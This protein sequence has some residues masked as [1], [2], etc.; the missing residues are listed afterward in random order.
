MEANLRRQ[1]GELFDGL[2]VRAWVSMIFSC[3]CSARANTYTHNWIRCM[4]QLCSCPWVPV[5]ACSVIFLHTKSRKRITPSCIWSCI[6]NWWKLGW[7]WLSGCVGHT[8]IANASAS[9]F[10]SLNLAKS[11]VARCNCIRERT[12]NSSFGASHWTLTPCTDWSIRRAK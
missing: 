6:R 10:L 8:I 9:A 7:W 11:F 2:C 5:I 4:Y 3:T 12:Q 1:N